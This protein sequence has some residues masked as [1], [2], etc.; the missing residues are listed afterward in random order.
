[1]KENIVGDGGFV[2]DR[3]VM[4]MA[5]VGEKWS[6][7]LHH[8]RWFCSFVYRVVIVVGLEDGRDE[9]EFIVRN[10]ATPRGS[11]V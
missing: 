5:L 1:M 8:T 11:V 4:M 3:Q 6:P 7:L 2:D 9:W 10:K